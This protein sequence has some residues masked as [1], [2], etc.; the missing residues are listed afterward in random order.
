[1]V[2]LSCLLDMRYLVVVDG[3]F[4]DGY[5]EL[6]GSTC[7][8][9]RNGACT[10]L[11]LHKKSVGYLQVFLLVARMFFYVPELIG[12]VPPDCHH[13]VL[14]YMGFVELGRHH[15][16]LPSRRCLILNTPIWGCTFSHRGN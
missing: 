6:R 1:M 12:S 8:T 2:L 5:A 3:S 4:I 16:S 13:P 10:Y 15:C 7:L 9:E 11:K 14:I